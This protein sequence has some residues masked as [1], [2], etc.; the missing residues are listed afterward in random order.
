MLRSN[1]GMLG[2][3]DRQ[4]FALREDKLQL[5]PGFL[6]TR[7]HGCS[8]YLRRTTALSRPSST[9]GIN[10]NL[11]TIFPTELCLSV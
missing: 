4:N 6:M 3:S 8:L 2:S 1:Y 5:P 11:V 7:E 10:H 9:C